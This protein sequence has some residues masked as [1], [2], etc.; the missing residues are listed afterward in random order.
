MTLKL[1][2]KSLFPALVQVLSPLMLVKAGSIY[3]FGLDI[4]ALQASFASIFAPATILNSVTVTAAGTYSVQTTDSVVLINKTVA[5]ANSVQLP[6]ANARGGLPVTVK[7]LKG[8]GATNNIT[9]LP[10]GAETIDGLANVPINANYGAYKF[11]P[12]TGG[13]VILP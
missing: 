8:D 13:W 3:T 12:V 4:N 9:V 6:A 2:V 1:R 7:D 11:W 10:A 5:A